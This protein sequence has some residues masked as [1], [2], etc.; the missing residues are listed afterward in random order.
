MDK[1]KHF[2]IKLLKHIWHASKETYYDNMSYSERCSNLNKW[3]YFYSK[4]DPVPKE[5]IKKVFSIM[6][7]LKEIFPPNH[8]C[9][10]SPYDDYLEPEKVLKLLIF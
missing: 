6:Y 3:L 5:F 7:N 1:Y 9:K 2:C 10:Y 4:I 8:I